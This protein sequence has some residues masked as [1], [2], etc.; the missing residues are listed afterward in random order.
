MEINLHEHSPEHIPKR[1]PTIT[2][3][4]HYGHRG[5]IYDS[6][7]METTQISHI[8]KLDIENIVH[9]HNGILLGY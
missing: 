6:Q 9:L 4:V 3:N 2:Q 7:K 8:E 5:I 1:C